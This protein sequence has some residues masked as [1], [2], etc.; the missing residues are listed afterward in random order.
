MTFAEETRS[1]LF[2]IALHYLVVYTRG[3]VKLAKDEGICLISAHRVSNCKAV[4]A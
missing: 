1:W 3:V 4:Y 2:Y